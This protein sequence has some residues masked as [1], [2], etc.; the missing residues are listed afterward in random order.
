MLNLLLNAQKEVHPLVANKILRLALW[1]VSGNPL[2]IQ[3]YQSRLPVL[4]PVL[5]G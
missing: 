5:E 4:I 3:G 2:L 1:K